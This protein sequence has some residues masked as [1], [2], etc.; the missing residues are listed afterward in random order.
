MRHPINLNIGILLFLALFIY[1]IIM[2]VLSL[3]AKRV[4][5]YEVREGSLAV[6]NSFEGICLRTEHLY[7]AGASGYINFYA[8]ENARVAKGELVY[9]VDGSGRLS[10]MISEGD[11]V[12]GAILSNEDLKELKNEVISWHASYTDRDFSEVYGFKTQIE[13]TASKLINSNAM[14]T[15]SSLSGN[16]VINDAVKLGYSAD[17]GIVV[18]SWDGLEDLTASGVNASLFDKSRYKQRQ[19]AANTLVG[20]DEP[21]YKLITEE[22]W[23]V[24]IPVDEERLEE[25][26]NLKYLNVRFLKNGYT[27]WGAVSVLENDDGSYLK[28]DFTNSMITFAGERFL[29]VEL[30]AGETTG[31]KIPNSAIVTKDFFIVPED[32]LTRG[33]EGLDGVMKRTYLEDGG[34]STEFIRTSVYYRDSLGVYL[35]KEVLNAGDILLKPDSSETFTVGETKSLTGVYDMNYGYAD[36]TRIDPLL[37]NKEYTIVSASSNYGLNVYDHIVLDGESVKNEDFTQ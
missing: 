27:S 24:V 37:S 16:S 21:A 5:G 1:I 23:S 14:R 15:I 12:N 26:R 18:Y 34:E 17:S 2:V 32:F 9:S 22:N 4:I 28:L 11:S 36:F 13:G 6:N 10:G 7:P 8:R 19:I 25:F 20:E 31:L 29:N 3:K 33:A 30:L 35:D